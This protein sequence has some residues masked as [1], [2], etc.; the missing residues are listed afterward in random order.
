VDANSGCVS[1]IVML[2]SWQIQGGAYANDVYSNCR[3]EK[4]EFYR[5]EASSGG[6]LYVAS[7][8]IAKIL[9]GLFDKN[10]GIN[11]GSIFDGGAVDIYDAKFNENVALNSVSHSTNQVYREM[12]I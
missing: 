1:D 12:T 5:N 4:S 6:A 3:F 2:G 7:Y 10:I 11:G 8:S 9:G